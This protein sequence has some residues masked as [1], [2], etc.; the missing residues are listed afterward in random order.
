MERF[1]S[2]LNLTKNAP[3]AVE[4]E[5]HQHL[6]RRKT[7][8]QTWVSTQESQQSPVSEQSPLTDSSPLH[9]WEL[10]SF[11]KP[12]FCQRCDKVILNRIES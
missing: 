7:V 10:Y 11:S 3:V 6:V 9:D 1:A 12:T 8:L 5:H 2:T 4:H